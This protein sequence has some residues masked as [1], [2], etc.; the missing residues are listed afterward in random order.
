MLLLK[1]AGDAA[2]ADS[3][4]GASHLSANERSLAGM[5]NSEDEERRRL[6]RRSMSLQHDGRTRVCS[7]MTTPDTGPDLYPIY[8]YEPHLLVF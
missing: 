8:M 3:R 2:G 7:V 1:L 6:A 4:V 5:Q